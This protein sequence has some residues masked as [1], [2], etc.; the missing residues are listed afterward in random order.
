MYHRGAKFMRHM[1]LTSNG[2]KFKFL[3]IAL[4]MIVACSYTPLTL[5]PTPSPRPK[6]TPLPTP[7]PVWIQIGYFDESPS[8]NWHDG[9]TIFMYRV[10]GK[11]ILK[12]YYFDGF[13]TV[14][15]LIQSTTQAAKYDIV[16]ELHGYYVLQDGVLGV[17]DGT[18]L[19]WEA[20]CGDPYYLDALFGCQ[21]P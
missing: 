4:L 1:L 9:T 17:Y 20:M 11:L 8:P 7:T 19:I 21:S 15:E 14:Q 5:A 12:S 3:V 10:D 18:R 13:S 2:S 6:P 16:G